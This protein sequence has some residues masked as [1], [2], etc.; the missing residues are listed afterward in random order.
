M[1]RRRPPPPALRRSRGRMPSPARFAGARSPRAG[2]STSS[3]RTSARWRRSRRVA[4]STTTS[5]RS[6]RRSA[7]RSGARS[8]GPRRS[9]R[10]TL[11]E[12]ADPLADLDAFID[13]H[14]RR[15]GAEG[16][17]P[18]DRAAGT[19]AASSSGACSS[20]SGPDGA[21]RLSVP[22]RRRA[23]DRVLASTSR[24]PTRSSTTTPAWT[25][26]PATCRRACS[27][28]SASCGA[29]WSA[30]SAGWTSSAADEDYKYEWGAVDEPIQRLLVRRR[31]G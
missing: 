13:L 30:G 16:L 18:A 22:D 27:W 26:M 25:P 7:T 31:V 4:R 20:C 8:A 11:T 3:A 24:R 29:R 14:Q 17:F 9:G 21:F 5:R 10:S 1:G 15:W 12:S 6:A 2:P 23:A 28:S 19:R